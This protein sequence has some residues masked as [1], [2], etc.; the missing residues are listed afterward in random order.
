MDGLASNEQDV[1]LS[2]V[3]MLDR[4]YSIILA[5]VFNLRIVFMRVFYTR[6][7]C[8]NDGSCL[9]P[10]H[11]SMCVYCVIH[12]ISYTW[13]WVEFGVLS[14]FQIIFDF[15]LMAKRTFPLQRHFPKLPNVCDGIFGFD[16]GY[17]LNDPIK[18]ACVC[19]VVFSVSLNRLWPILSTN[20]QWCSSIWLNILCH[21]PLT[22]TYHVLL[23]TW[24]CTEIKIDR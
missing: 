20:F 2:M 11:I 3:R 8:F 9:W 5:V 12:C 4:V 14:N 7:T 21:T 13:I 6:Y 22:V 16:K 15:Y 23:W 18:C 10:L 17:I 24:L 1:R 19:W